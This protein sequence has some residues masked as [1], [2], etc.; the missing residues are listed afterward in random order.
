[1]PSQNTN[2]DDDDK[3]TG[4]SLF[5]CELAGVCDSDGRGGGCTVY[6]LDG[7]AAGHG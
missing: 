3:V 6:R 2:N 5:P 7:D 1:M 4:V